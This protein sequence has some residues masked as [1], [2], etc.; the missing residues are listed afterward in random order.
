[1][2]E[3]RQR[4]RVRETLQRGDLCVMVET[5]GDVASIYP[6]QRVLRQAL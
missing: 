1:M 3:S 6:A 4:L 2:R 5:D